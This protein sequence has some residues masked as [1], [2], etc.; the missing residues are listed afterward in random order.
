LRNE[1]KRNETKRNETKRNETKR[2]ETRHDQAET[3]VPPIPNHTQQF[4]GSVPTFRLDTQIIISSAPW[5]VFFFWKTIY[6]G[7]T[8]S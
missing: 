2:N 4:K 3:T 1:T 8:I 6:P 5:L 7:F